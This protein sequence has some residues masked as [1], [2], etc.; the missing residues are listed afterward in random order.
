MVR[1]GML[2]VIFFFFLLFACCSYAFVAGGMAER[3]T[4]ALMLAATGLTI[5][6]ERAPEM[7]NFRTVNLGVMGV[8][9]AFLIGLLLVAILSRRYWPV[10]MAGLQL[11]QV[12]AHVV[13][14]VDPRLLP[15]GYAVVLA[16]WCYP[17]LLILAVGTFR[18]RHGSAPRGMG[19]P[20]SDLRHRNI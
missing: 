3:T 7:R 2:H 20:A 16:L 11:V 4:A 1:L 8:D 6:V 17:M 19:L 9:T 14:L 15:L 13:R 12:A 10:W 5:L 18:H